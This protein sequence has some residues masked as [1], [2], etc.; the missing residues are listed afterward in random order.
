[1]GKEKVIVGLLFF[2]KTAKTPT[3]EAYRAAYA[4]PDVYVALPYPR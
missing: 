1:M 3:A 4:S 2:K